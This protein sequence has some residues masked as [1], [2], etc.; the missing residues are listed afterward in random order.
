MD[1]CRNSRFFRIWKVTTFRG[2]SSAQA[3]L[4]SVKLV[5]SMKHVNQWLNNPR[6]VILKSSKNI[7]TIYLCENYY[8]LNRSLFWFWKLQDC[9]KD[10][11]WIFAIACRMNDMLIALNIVAVGTEIENQ[12][13]TEYLNSKCSMSW[14]IKFDLSKTTEIYCIYICII[15]KL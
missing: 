9:S 4:Q 14:Q 11:N 6:M 5:H 3:P 13:G 15:I 1:I 2:Q 10:L 12:E 7:S 8:L